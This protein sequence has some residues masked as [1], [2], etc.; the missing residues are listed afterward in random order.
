MKAIRSSFP[1]FSDVQVDVH[2]LQFDPFPLICGLVANKTSRHYS[3][4]GVIR[5]PCYWGGIA[6]FHMNFLTCFLW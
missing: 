3:A 1:F 2:F 5:H 4:N 6:S